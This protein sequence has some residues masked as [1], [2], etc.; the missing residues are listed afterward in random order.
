MCRVTLRS[1]ATLVRAPWTVVPI[2]RG[3]RRKQRGGTR[4]LYEAYQ[5]IFG[6]ILLMVYLTRWHN[7]ADKV[8][9]IG[10]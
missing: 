5:S 8:G 1:P 7:P 2:L 3:M 9:R 6:L 4:L 10:S